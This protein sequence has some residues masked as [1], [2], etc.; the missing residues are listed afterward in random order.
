MAD[1]VLVGRLGKPPQLG[2]E[3]VQLLAGQ[4]KS[5][6]AHD[7]FLGPV[8]RG[9]RLELGQKIEQR[10]VFAPFLPKHIQIIGLDGNVALV[11][12][13]MGDQQMLMLLGDG[14]PAQ[15]H[16]KDSGGMVL[17]GLIGQNGGDAAVQGLVGAME[18]AE[19]DD[20]QIA[21]NRAGEQNV[22][23]VHRGGNHGPAPVDFAD[24]F[25]VNLFVAVEL[26]RC[27][28]DRAVGFQD[29]DT[30]LKLVDK[31]Q[32]GFQIDMIGLQ[33]TLEF[34]AVGIRDEGISETGDELQQIIAVDLAQRIAAADLVC[35]AEV[36]IC[37]LRQGNMENI[38][39]VDD[40]AQGDMLGS[41]EHG[42]QVSLFQGKA[43]LLQHFTETELAVRTGVEQGLKIFPDGLFVLIAQLL[44]QQ[45]GCAFF[46]VHDLLFH[47]YLFSLYRK[48]RKNQFSE[49]FC[50]VKKEYF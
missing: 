44:G 43:P 5:A 35:A 19:A 1:L 10:S 3:G 37:Q 6:K 36:L 42:A 4:E 27:L 23:G 31:R 24:T 2:Q 47:M 21:L 28:T 32:G 48:P 34:R 16:S 26:E 17:S 14:D 25:P 13:E 33:I 22:N 20:G 29:K 8:I 38:A 18:V 40:Q 7:I 30:G 11:E 9:D 12:V 50:F 15:E 49:V 45:G 39:K 41:L 46:H